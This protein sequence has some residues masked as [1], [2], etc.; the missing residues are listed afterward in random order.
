MG[1]L[2]FQFSQ[3]CPLLT[4]RDFT[5]QFNLLSMAFIYSILNIIDYMPRFVYCIVISSFILTT[6]I[7]DTA[8][9]CVDK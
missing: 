1:N 4:Q 8:P 3:I 7:V 5:F 2:N 9:K 6:C